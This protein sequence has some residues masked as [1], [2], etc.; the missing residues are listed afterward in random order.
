MQS[1]SVIGGGFLVAFLAV[2]GFIGCGP[3]ETPAVFTPGSGENPLDGGVLQDDGLTYSFSSEGEEVDVTAESRRLLFDVA[4]GVSIPKE[5]L[6]LGGHRLQYDTQSRLITTFANVFGGQTFVFQAPEDAELFNGFGRGASQNLTTCSNAR[7]AVDGFCGAF[8]QNSDQA[9]DTVVQI[10]LDEAR[11]N[12]LPEVA[13][14]IVEGIIREFFGEL[15]L[16]CEAW[17]EVRQ[18]QD[19]CSS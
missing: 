18:T 4:T 5:I 15:G 9:V 19:P 11:K 16:F 3:V 12:G 6:T 2:A 13:Y 17:D 8:L 7:D 1:R 14:G 10:A